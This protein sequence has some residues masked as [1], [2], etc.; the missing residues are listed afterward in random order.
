M[1]LILR[2]GE[3]TRRLLIAAFLAALGTGALAQQAAGSFV[4]TWKGDVPGIG[5]ATLVISALRS[6]GQVEGRM[7]FALQG[8]VSTFADK[9]DSAKRT[10]KG[11][12]SDGTLT[13]EAALGGRYVL[14]RT[15]DG[16]SGR[17]TRG[18][19]LDVPVTLRKY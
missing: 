2:R 16:L 9:A 3:T 6:D 5:E 18:T 10:N 12:V 11:T 15:G 4:G 19:T 7:E 14:Q 17:Y 8:F 13:I 1:G